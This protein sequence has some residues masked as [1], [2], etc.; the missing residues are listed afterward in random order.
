[1]YIE[2]EGAGRRYFK[3][4]RVGQLKELLSSIPDDSVI[5]PNHITG[6]LTVCA[7]NGNLS[8]TDGWNAVA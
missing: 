5:Y 7:T 4:M 8:A 1:M 3:L 2:N 6:N